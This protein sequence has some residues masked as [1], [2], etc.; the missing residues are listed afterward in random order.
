MGGAHSSLRNFMEFSIHFGD[1]QGSTIS[2]L[3]RPESLRTRHGR[4]RPCF[5]YTAPQKQY[6]E[7][8][9]KCNQDAFFFFFDKL[10][11]AQD[12]GSRFGQT[13]SFAIITYATVPGDCI[14][15][16]TSQNGDRVIFERLAKQHPRSRW[17]VI[18]KHSSNNSSRSSL[19]S[20][21]TFQASG[22]SVLPRKA[23]QSARRHERRHGSRASIQETGA[24]HFWS[25][26]WYSDFH[27]R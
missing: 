9:W 18:D 20:R 6:Y 19:L 27:K 2:V 8:R 10:S 17:R 3:C 7:T 21:M 1:W 13:K 14:D 26:S 22:N 5:Y 24:C 11:R 23:F 15:R 12:Q 4:R 25:G 16:V